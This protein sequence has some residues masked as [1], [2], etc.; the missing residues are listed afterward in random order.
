[1]KKSNFLEEN[2]I[3]LNSKCFFSLLCR[4]SPYTNKQKVQAM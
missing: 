3:K 4:I 1:M 2:E